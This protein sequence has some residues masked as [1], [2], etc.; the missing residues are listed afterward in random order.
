VRGLAF[1]ACRDRLA[2]NGDCARVARRAVIG[3]LRRV[4]DTLLFTH[5][6]WLASRGWRTLRLY[7]GGV[8]RFVSCGCRSMVTRCSHG[9]SYCTGGTVRILDHHRTNFRC[10]VRRRIRAGWLQALLNRHQGKQLV[11][12]GDCPFWLRS[13][14]RR[15]CRHVLRI[16]IV[17]REMLHWD[18][19][20]G[21]LMGGRA[22]KTEAKDL[23]LVRLRAT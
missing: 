6:C 10:N 3:L 8:W 22:R 17:C 18:W 20:V 12:V 1:V 16:R 14:G 23:R 7:V 15:I 2:A 11:V 21:G 13:G 19:A 9:D 4:N 5:R